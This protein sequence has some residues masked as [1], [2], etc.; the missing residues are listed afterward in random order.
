TNGLTKDI[1]SQDYVAYLAS[2]AT[3]KSVTNDG[4]VKAD[5]KRL[6]AAMT[7]SPIANYAFR[8]E[9]GA[10][11]FTNEAKS[12][13]LATPSFSSGA[14]YG[15]L[16]GDGALDLVVNNV[17]QEA[18]VYRNNARTLRPENRFLRVRL[19]GEG[20]NRFAIGARVTA[21]AG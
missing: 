1:T 18:F 6:T 13:G 21:Y 8:N 14:A 2:D 10:A 11:H 5:F 7:S 16:D 20:M 4:K 9:G 15:D 12:W 17:D 19:A 3:M